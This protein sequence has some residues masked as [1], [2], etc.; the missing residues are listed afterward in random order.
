MNLPEK[1]IWLDPEKHPDTQHTRLSG[2]LKGDYTYAVAEFSRVYTFK[3]PVTRL[4]LRFSGDTAFRLSLTGGTIATGPVPV[5]GDFL[6]NTT[7]RSKHYASEMTLTPDSDRLEFFAEV[8][9]GP[10]ELFEYSRGQGG[11][12]L[13]G[14]VTFVDGS[15]EIINTNRSWICRKNGAY[16][17][18]CSYDAS[19]SSAA[20][21]SACEMPDIWHA[22]TA[23]LRLLSEEIITLDEITL[24]PGETKELDI[25]LEKIVAANLAFTVKASGTVRVTATSYETHTDPTV[26]TEELTFISDD[27]YRGFKIHSVGGLM[28]KLENRSDVPASVLPKVIAVCYPAENCAVTRVSDT[29]LNDVLDVCAHTLKYCRQHIH[30]DSPRHCEPLACT[31]DYY[32]ESLMT[33]FSFGDMALAEFDII[34]TAELLRQNDGRM[35]HTTY[36]LIW[37][38]MLYDVY[39]FTGHTELLENCSAALIRLLNRF[40]GYLGENG[41]VETPPDYMFIDWLYIDGISMHHPPKAL[42]QTCLN[43]YYFGALQTAVKIFAAL[44]DDAMAAHC[45]KKS[46]ALQAAVNSL[47]FDPER[48][49]YFEGLNTPT[50]EHMLYHYM[51]Q[52]VEKRYYRKHANILA[53][54]TGIC[55]KE[56]AQDLLRRIMA[57]EIEGDYQPYF[58]HFLLEAIF[59]SGLREE[60]TLTVLER[61]KAPVREC[62]KGLAEGFIPPEPTYKFDHSHAW[63]GTPLWSLPLSL[64]GL[65]I[66]EPGMKKLRFSPSLLGLEHAEVQ[67]PTPCGMVTLEMEQGKAPVISAPDEIEV[68]LR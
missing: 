52:N 32:I 27:E 12:M 44:G 25:E 36:S 66:L 55:G 67:L 13:A 35:F 68:V 62:P 6:S 2:D 57:D 59:R 8:K 61:W 11:F 31:G 30:L 60:F 19:L 49:M 56:L 34:R 14:C 42:G 50:P 54:Y 51:P 26:L 20:W 16:T 5:G 4:D 23:P 41:L 33:A 65:E 21:D 29:E 53:A 9:L 37:V 24:A 15:K 64:T 17:S 10:S 1:W 7:P 43:I 45:A 3:K 58:A 40:D 18:P 63:G 28:L 46:A 47:L 39:R 48:Q 22:E 38:Q